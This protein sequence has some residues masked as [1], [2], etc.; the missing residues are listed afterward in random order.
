MVKKGKG[1]RVYCARRAQLK[2]DRRYTC[3]RYTY[4]RDMNNC[5][6]T[7]YASQLVPHMRSSLNIVRAIGSCVCVCVCVLALL[8]HPYKFHCH[9]HRAHAMRCSFR[10]T[11]AYPLPFLL[12]SK[13][14]QLVISAVLFQFS[15]SLSLSLRPIL[16]PYRRMDTTNKYKKK[17]RERDSPTSIES[18]MNSYLFRQ[19]DEI[20]VEIEIE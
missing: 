2:G 10:S 17:N 8:I 13:S 4:T 20:I 11:T 18:I 6:L 5:N 19:I 16:Y 9:R 14:F 15:V 1:K 7:G 12:L 3:I